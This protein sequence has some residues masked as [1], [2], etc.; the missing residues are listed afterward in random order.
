MTVE[1]TRPDLLYG[2]L[3]LPLWALIVWPRAGRGVRYTRGSGSAR[4]APWSWAPAAMVL[5]R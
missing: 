4:R 1:F 3:L 2:L 5:L